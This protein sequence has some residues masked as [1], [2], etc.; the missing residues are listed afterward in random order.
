[1]NMENFKNYLKEHNIYKFF[2]IEWYINGYGIECR[3][4]VKG[5]NKKQIAKKICDELNQHFLELKN[6]ILNEPNEC[7]TIHCNEQAKELNICPHC[8]V[9]ITDPK[10]SCCPE[11]EKDHPEI[12][13]G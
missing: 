7:E 4:A 8:G 12:F 6:K 5:K 9:N 10:F 11:Y 3:L 1:M 13:N 2:D